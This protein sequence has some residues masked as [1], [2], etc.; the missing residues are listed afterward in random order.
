MSKLGQIT[1]R[2]CWIS[3]TILGFYMALD[4]ISTIK[5]KNRNVTFPD[6]R[7][8]R[9]HSDFTSEMEAVIRATRV[10][11]SEES[12]I[13]QSN[14]KSAKINRFGYPDNISKLFF[15]LEFKVW[16]TYF[17]S[18]YPGITISDLK[19]KLE[20]RNPKEIFLL[21]FCFNPSHLYTFSQIHGENVNVIDVSNNELQYISVPLYKVN[22]VMSLDL[23]IT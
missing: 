13:L 12:A 7:T 21:T 6:G 17:W 15:G 11:F 18:R 4:S 5:I 23:N 19:N 10:Y 22:I 14:F 8:I 1:S 16:S 9:L 3:A 2:D 20:T